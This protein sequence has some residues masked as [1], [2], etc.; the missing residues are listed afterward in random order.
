MNSN[1]KFKHVFIVESLKSFSK[2]HPG[3]LGMDGGE[4]KLLRSQI[5]YSVRILLSHFKRCAEKEEVWATC[6]R[7]YTGSH[8]L[9]PVEKLL[10]KVTFEEDDDDNEYS[11]E[12]SQP[13]SGVMMV[14]WPALQS[15]APQIDLWKVLGT[16]P[17]ISQCFFL[18]YLFQTSS[19]S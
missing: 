11:G 9:A 17:K 7:A 3:K 6:K 14:D 10:A 2:L 15:N 16:T 18:W 1:L 5:S 4:A 13:T 12:P 8:D 19:C